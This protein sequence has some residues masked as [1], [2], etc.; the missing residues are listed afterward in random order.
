M[1]PLNP[2]CSATP[3]RMNST[4]R[5]YRTTIILGL[6][7]WLGTRL[8]EN[9]LAHI[10]RI[11]IDNLPCSRFRSYCKSVPTAGTGYCRIDLR[12]LL[13][14]A[15]IFDLIPRRITRAALLAY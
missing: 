3:G 4:P 6:A 12:Y 10:P 7:S 1:P 14:P 9:D 2:Q 13:Q 11:S 5:H 8:G 15:T